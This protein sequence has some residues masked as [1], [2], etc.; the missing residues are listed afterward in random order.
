MNGDLGVSPWGGGAETRQ[1]HGP[2]TTPATAASSL[3]WVRSASP[4]DPRLG[5]G[6]AL[7][8]GTVT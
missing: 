7:S 4:T 6:L 1:A 3:T 8:H 5:C 2:S